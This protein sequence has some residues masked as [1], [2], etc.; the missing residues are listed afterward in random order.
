MILE[1]ELQQIKNIKKAYVQLYKGDF[2]NEATYVFFTGCEFLNN[3]GCKIEVQKFDYDDIGTLDIDKDTIVAGGITAVRYGLSV[4]GANLPTPLDIPEELYPYTKRNIQLGTIKSVMENGEFP[5]FVKPRLPKLFTGMVVCHP[6]ELEMF[7]HLHTEDLDLEIMT[8][9]VVKFV[10][11]YR[12]F[13]IDGQTYDCRK[14]SGDHR[15]TPDFNFIEEAVKAYKT[16][17]ISYSLDFG[18]TD[19]GETMLIE[20]NDGYSLGT[21]G[22]DSFNYVRMCILRWNQLLNNLQ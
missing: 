1:K 16:A 4:L 19:K 11:E 21:Y 3:L 22:F 6:D 14:Y 5:L 20:A 9:D 2:A 8:S 7:R 18:V 17:P 10:S 13:V 12:T 15:V